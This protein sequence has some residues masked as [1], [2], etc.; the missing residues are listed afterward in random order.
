MIIER[1]F[2]NRLEHKEKHICFQKTVEKI[3]Y[4][5]SM[6]FFPFQFSSFHVND[7]DEL[8]MLN[9]NVE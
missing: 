9:E 3:Q 6:P 1:D 7:A 5:I 2:V 4:E 8:T